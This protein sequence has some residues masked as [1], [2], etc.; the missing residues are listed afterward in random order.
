MGKGVEQLEL[1]RGIRETLERIFSGFFQNIP[2]WAFG[3]LVFTVSASGKRSMGGILQ[4]HGAAAR[5]RPE[6]RGGES[7]HR[8]LQPRVPGFV[9]PVFFHRAASPRL[10]RGSRVVRVPR[11]PTRAATPVFARSIKRSPT[12]FGK[13]QRV[14]RSRESRES[15][16]ALASH[17]PHPKGFW[18][19]NWPLFGTAGDS[20]AGGGAGKNSREYPKSSG[21][22]KMD[23]EKLAV[24]GE[25]DFG[26]VSCP[27]GKWPPTF[28]SL[29]QRCTLC[30][31]LF[32]ELSL[33]MQLGPRDQAAAW[34]RP[35]AP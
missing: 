27:P 34:I 2:F 14:P 3:F 29:G 5:A 11:G 24:M 4:H 31:F 21:T 9:F 26:W 20:Q 10:L 23:Q 22:S 6:P 1:F 18:Q 25:G 30:L 15:P 12:S 28:P 8:A 13:Y 17:L 16:A 32:P 7:P 19:R 35:P 33:R